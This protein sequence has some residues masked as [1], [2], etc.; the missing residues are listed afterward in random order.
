MTDSNTVVCGSG[1]AGSDVGGEDILAGILEA[2]DRYMKVDDYLACVRL[3]GDHASIIKLYSMR[4]SVGFMTMALRAGAKLSEVVSIPGLSG[5]VGMLNGYCSARRNGASHSET[6]EARG[7]GLGM[8]AYGT[9]LPTGCT[10]DEAIALLG[11]IRGVEDFVKCRELGASYAECLAVG[12][13]G[14]G[15]YFLSLALKVGISVDEVLSFEGSSYE[16]QRFI[17][18]RR[19]VKNA[20]IAV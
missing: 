15:M 10:H 8:G 13:K 20:L 9:V 4:V 3:G 12:E 11:A 7:A 5:D 14:G 6:M 1:V 16:L 17:E 2:T 18:E 19:S